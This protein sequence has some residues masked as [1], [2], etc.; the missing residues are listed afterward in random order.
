MQELEEHMLVQEE[1]MVAW[2]QEE[3]MTHRV[4][5]DSFET[6]REDHL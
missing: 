6:L 4:V 5:D 3:Y 2:H 1:S